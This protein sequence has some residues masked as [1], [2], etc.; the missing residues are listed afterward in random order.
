[1]TFVDDEFIIASVELVIEAIWI[2]V[3]SDGFSP[4]GTVAEGGG[5]RGEFSD[6]NAFGEYIISIPFLLQ[7]LMCSFLFDDCFLGCRPK[8]ASAEQSKKKKDNVNLD[9][10]I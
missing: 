7:N 9:L 8:T 3:I 2:V 6:S 5:L 4:N 1:L 10:Q